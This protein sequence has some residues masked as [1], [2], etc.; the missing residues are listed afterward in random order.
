MNK[1]IL[2]SLIILLSSLMASS[3]STGSRTFGGSL[4]FYKD[5]NAD[6]SVLNISPRFGYF[7]NSNLMFEIGINHVEI[8]VKEYN[9]DTYEGRYNNG[10]QYTT[11]LGARLFMKNFYAG[12]EFVKGF[13]AS[14]S[15]GLGNQV[16]IGSLDFEGSDERGLFKL[17]LL[18]PLSKQIYLD[19]A[20]HYMFILDK[21]K[22]KLA[23]EENDEFTRLAYLTLG[24]SYIW[25][26]KK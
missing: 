23:E 16:T 12:F 1:R 24:I 19:S 22:R 7:V 9:A 4:S 18:T 26:P 14:M 10:E 20:L 11:S 8:D 5:L 15:T 17:G 21:D 2:F 25:E 3:F 13:S 6:V